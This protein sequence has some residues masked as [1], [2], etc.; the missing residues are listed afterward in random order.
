[1]AKDSQPLDFD[2]NEFSEL[3]DNTISTIIP[4]AMKQNEINDNDKTL[5]STLPW[6]YL[7][8]LDEIPTSTQKSQK[9]G[10]T[11]K[12]AEVTFDPASIDTSNIV[13]AKRKRKLK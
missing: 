10:P 5:D 12:K 2:C 6:F 4:P 8:S 3:L 9:K 7:T 11:K 13:Q 1:M